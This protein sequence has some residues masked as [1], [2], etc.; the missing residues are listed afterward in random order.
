MTEIEIN[1]IFLYYFNQ[2]PRV[3]FQSRLDAFASC[4]FAVYLGFSAFILF[5]R[6]YF[7]TSRRN[8][9]E[10]A[11]ATTQRSTRTA[12]LQHGNSIYIKNNIVQHTLVV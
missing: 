10:A 8:S 3:T 12:V 4:F 2:I 1:I 6:R 5:F 9:P 7:A 11:S